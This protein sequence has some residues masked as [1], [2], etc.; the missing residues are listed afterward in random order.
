MVCNRKVLQCYATEKRPLYQAC[1]R[2]KLCAKSR[3]ATELHRIDGDAT[4]VVV[5]VL[6][7]LLRL[8]QRGEAVAIGRGRATGE[9]IGAEK[10]LPGR[11]ASMD[12]PRLM[13][14]RQAGRWA[15][16]S[17][18]RSGRGSKATFERCRRLE[19]NRP[20]GG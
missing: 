7:E 16:K 4:D 1:V 2:C 6:G 5:R 19:I 18:S 17:V 9:G 11:Q 12:K 10:P 13:R 20:F 8:K 3:Y 14:C 15:D